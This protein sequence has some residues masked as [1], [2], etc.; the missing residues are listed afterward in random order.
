VIFIRRA[1]WQGACFVFGLSAASEFK[2]GVLEPEIYAMMVAGLGFSAG[3][4]NAENG[5][6]PDLSLCRP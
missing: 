5:L 2:C 1:F 3:L 4:E 6:L